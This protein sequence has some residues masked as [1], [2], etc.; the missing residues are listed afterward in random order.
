MVISSAHSNPSVVVVAA[1]VVV[2]AA[3]VVVPSSSSPLEAVRVLGDTNN[4]WQACWIQ[5]K[6]MMMI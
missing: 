6:Q 3:V 1:I 5:E 2:V 4:A